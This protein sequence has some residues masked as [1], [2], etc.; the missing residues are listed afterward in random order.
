MV[1]DYYINHNNKIISDTAKQIQ[2]Y[3]VAY[4]SKQLTYFDFKKLVFNTL[5]INLTNEKLKDRIKIEQAFNGMLK[6]LDLEA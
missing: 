3:R 6:L 5:N 1:L 4:T 2:K